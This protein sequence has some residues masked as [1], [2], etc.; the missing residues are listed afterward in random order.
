AAPDRQSDTAA[1]STAHP[2]GALAPPPPRFHDISLVDF[3]ATAA[4]PSRQL[5]GAAYD[6]LDLSLAVDS[7]VDAP[8]ASVGQGLDPARRAEIDPAGQLAHDHQ[9]ETG[10]EVALEARRVGKRIEHHRRPQ[11]GEQIH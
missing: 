8:A 2:L 11:I 9:I 6:A 1:T 4:A 3:A 10:D 5:A 7:R